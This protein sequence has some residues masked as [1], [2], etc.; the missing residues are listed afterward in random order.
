[1]AS[2]P[3]SSTRNSLQSCVGGGCGGHSNRT[4]LSA[5]LF[6]LWHYPGMDI[7]AE[8]ASYMPRY[9]HEVWGQTI[10]HY[11]HVILPCPH[12]LA[13]SVPCYANGNLNPRQP[14]FLI[15][16]FALGE[17]CHHNME[18]WLMIAGGSCGAVRVDHCDLWMSPVAVR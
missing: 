6:N 13:L 1:M 15:L 5:V 18:H 16:D 3:T 14:S 12:F 10:A 8:Y 9:N 11:P 2:G 4:S 7:H 17:R